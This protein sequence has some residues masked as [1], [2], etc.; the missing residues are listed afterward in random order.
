MYVV[1]TF[2]DDVADL[3]EAWLAAEVL[4]NAD[5]VV[6]SRPAQPKP[7][8]EKLVGANLITL[9]NAEIWY[10]LFVADAPNTPNKILLIL[11]W[12]SETPLIQD[13]RFKLHIGN[14]EFA[15]HTQSSSEAI[16]LLA[17]ANIE[18]S[19]T[20]KLLSPRKLVIKV[21]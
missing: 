3:I 12:V 4:P 10:E 5:N 6:R 16:W 11:R 14:L 7:H 21:D 9:D 20:K 13:L 19:K 17:K 1:H 15:T 18:D 2:P 8:G